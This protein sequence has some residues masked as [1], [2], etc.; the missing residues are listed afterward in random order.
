MTKVKYR[1]SVPAPPAKRM[2]GSGK[3]FISTTDGWCPGP[4]RELP[5]SPDQT[6]IEFDVSEDFEWVGTTSCSDG[7]TFSI[8][9]EYSNSTGSRKSKVELVPEKVGA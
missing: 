7:A 9:I 1:A 6:E 2:S 3:C 5:L 4:T 8:W